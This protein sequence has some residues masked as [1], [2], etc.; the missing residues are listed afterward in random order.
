MLLSSGGSQLHVHG[1][2]FENLHPPVAT[3]DT[4]QRLE[5]LGSNG[6]EWLC[7]FVMFEMLLKL[8]FF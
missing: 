1:L 2:F 7:S 8:L 6:S 4:H 5:V 3:S